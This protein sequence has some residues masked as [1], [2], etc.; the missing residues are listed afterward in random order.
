M[1]ESIRLPML[2][3]L[4]KSNQIMRKFEITIMLFCQLEFA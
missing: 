1:S 2:K 3:T 4:K